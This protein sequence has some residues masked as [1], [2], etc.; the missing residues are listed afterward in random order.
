[1]LTT[2]A[3]KFDTRQNPFAPDPDLRIWLD[4][5]LVPESEA[6]V[7]VFDHGL[8]YG[9]GVFEGIRIYNGKIFKEEEHID[10]IYE[11][12]KSIMLEIPMT[13]E[14]ISK[15]MYAARDANNIV[16]G[17]IRL[18]VTRGVGQLGISIDKATCPSV[19]VIAATIQLYPP[20]LYEKGLRCITCGTMRNHPSA[21]SPRVKSL[22]YLNNIMAKFEAQSAGADEALM[23]NAQG[24]IT[25]G[26]GDN[27]FVIR[28]G[29]LRTPPPCDGILEGITRR[30]VMELARDSG[31][32]VSES[33]IIRHDIYV[34]DECFLT[35]TAAEIIPVVSLDQ[36]TI[37][38][39]KPGPITKSLMA[40]FVSYRNQ[41]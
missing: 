28:R 36:R 13:R 41:A 38:D 39:G 22:N 7:S 31:H 2:P 25:E 9:D 29:E 27:L 17:Y 12:A 32:E 19:I 35:G 6:R 10:R 11:S 5:Q 33:A 23:Q 20:E 26:T 15:A 18:V 24:H 34:A 3:S 16:D 14:E 8:L 1:M 30:L 40:Q 21:T 37:G 4:G